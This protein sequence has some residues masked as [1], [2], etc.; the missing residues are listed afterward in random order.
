M[1]GGGSGGGAHFP[2]PPGNGKPW[3]VRVVS[4]AGPSRLG[5]ACVHLSLPGNVGLEVRIPIGCAAL[6]M[7][8]WQAF[9][10]LL[11]AAPRVG[12]APAT[13]DVFRYPNVCQ[14]VGWSPALET[15]D[16]NLRGCR[17]MGRKKSTFANGA[18]NGVHNGI[19]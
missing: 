2:P 19:H 10:P 7:P 14:A 1:W 11:Q 15:K 9:R 13:I 12:H 5:S 3:P 18:A 4:T 16:Q 6:Q 17:I 8:F